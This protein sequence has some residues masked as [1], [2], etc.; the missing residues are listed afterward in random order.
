M[1][2]L[3][4]DIETVPFDV[5]DISAA[6]SPETAQ[7]AVI[8]VYDLERGLGTL[9]LVGEEAELSNKE[10][11][12]IKALSEAALL[13]EFADGAGQYDTF[14]GFGSR[15]F[16]AP[17]LI[18]R[19]LAQRVSPATRLRNHS[20]ITRQTLPFHVD[21]LDE[22]SFNGTMTKPPS[23]SGLADMYNLKEAALIARYPTVLEWYQENNQKALLNHMT[24]KLAAIE[25]LYEL[26]RANLAPPSF[27]NTIDL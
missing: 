2:T 26:W 7:L 16:D 15:R 10:D 11:W 5:E 22:F 3:L 4:F 13:S 8:G 6:L 23:L 19:A 25:A 18:H 14:V 17:F 21:L 1:A 27:M 20:R 9:Y 12:G 24:A